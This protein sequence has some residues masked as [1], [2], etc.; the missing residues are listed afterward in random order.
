M[1]ATGLISSPDP[2]GM[3]QIRTTSASKLQCLQNLDRNGNFMKTK[4]EY[5]NTAIS[6]MF[7]ELFEVGS[8]ISNE[9][10]YCP[11]NNVIYS[12]LWILRNPWKLMSAHIDKTTLTTIFEF[13]N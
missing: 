11:R 4:F 8:M 6:S 12:R 3:S 10:D 9:I 5:K 7:V 1:A 13:L 2:V